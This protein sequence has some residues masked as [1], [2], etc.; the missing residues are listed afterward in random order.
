MKEKK[1]LVIFVH[2][3]PQHVQ[4][5]SSCL[6]CAHFFMSSGIPNSADR[7]GPIMSSLY[8]NNPLIQQALA[9]KF[10]YCTSQLLS[11]FISSLVQ[12]HDVMTTVVIMTLLPNI[13]FH[14]ELTESLLFKKKSVAKY[15][16]TKTNSFFLSQKNEILKDR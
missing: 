8:K 7:P 11:E 9:M 10:M 4:M 3:L 14:L 2:F 12:H 1:T 15:L 16:L 6:E 13:M 5:S